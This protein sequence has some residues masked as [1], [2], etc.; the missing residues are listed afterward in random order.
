ML[1]PPKYSKFLSWFTGWVSTIG[2]NANTAAGAF[3]GATV[4]Q[5][6]LVINYPDYPY[7]RWHGTL[8]LYAAL[9]VVVLVNTIGARLL[10]KIEGMILIL[11]TLGF[12]AVLIP[13][14]Y[15]APHGS[16]SFVFK[17]FLLESGWNNKGVAWLIGLISTN[18]PFI[19]M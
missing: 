17:D 19:G 14:V 16:A 9:V 13:L 10:P 12:F 1:A 5:G 18:L 15:L 7:E 6:L 8:L 3:F 2:W 4:I 11:H